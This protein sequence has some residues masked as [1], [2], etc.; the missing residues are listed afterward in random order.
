[1]PWLFRVQ[2]VRGQRFESSLELAVD[3]AE[4][5]VVYG[6]GVGALEQGAYNPTLTDWANPAPATNLVTWVESHD[7]YANAHESA[8][9]SD[10]SQKLFRS[11][12]G[13]SGSEG[14]PM[15]LAVS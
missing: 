3:N 11:A 6:V 15:C 5:A 14:R 1:M 12:L 2:D 4:H 7:T 13:S 10:V 9:L 8:G